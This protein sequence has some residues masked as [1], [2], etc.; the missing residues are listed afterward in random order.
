MEA[1]EDMAL[2]DTIALA[3]A[4]QAT[5]NSGTYQE[6]GKCPNLSFSLWKVAAD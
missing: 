5:L 2:P 4:N 3:R 1:V 6:L